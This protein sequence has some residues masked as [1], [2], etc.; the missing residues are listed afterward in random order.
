MSLTHEW[1]AVEVKPNT[2]YWDEPSEMMDPGWFVVGGPK[3][4]DPEESAP[5]ILKVELAT[6]DSGYTLQTLA[7]AVASALR[8]EA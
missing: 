7:H 2:P 5:L 3:S 8:G 4:D 6:E 1:R